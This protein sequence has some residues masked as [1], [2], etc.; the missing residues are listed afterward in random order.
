MM[1][2]TMISQKSVWYNCEDETSETFFLD[3]LISFQVPVASA[4]VEC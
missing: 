1:T 2:L 3:F 4:V